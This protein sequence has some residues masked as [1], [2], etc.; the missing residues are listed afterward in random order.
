[1]N[2]AIRLSELE[3]LAAESTQGAATAPAT[4]VQFAVSAA[5][6]A[7]AA[8]VEEPWLQLEASTILRLQCQ[9]CLG[10]ADLPVEFNRS[11]RFVATEA[12]AEIEDEESEED[13]LV[14]EKQFNLQELIEDELLM[15]M[16]LVPMHAVC[17]VAVRL[18]AADPDFDATPAEKPN[19]FA[20]LG[21][22]KSSDG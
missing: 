17:P 7:D 9:R 8:G 5:M 2:G 18:A 15:A 14:L 10:D 6:R 22:L 19:P 11:F 21:K 3:R 1:M 13:V 12:L 4:E 20:I 16:P